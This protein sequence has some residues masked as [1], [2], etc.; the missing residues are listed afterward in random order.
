MTNPTS[1]FNWQMPTASDLVT[2]L[3]ADFETFG[4]AVDTSLADLKGGTTG[5]V[6]SKASNT[7]MDFNWVAADDTNAIQ[8]TI[9]DAK[10]DLIS[11]TGSDVPARLAVGANGETLVADSST[12]TGLRYQSGYNGNVVINGGFDVWQRSTSA[13][14]AGTVIYP[15]VDRWI[16]VALGSSPTCTM[17]RQTADTTNLTYG[18]RFGRNSGQTAI[19]DVYVGSAFE[20]IDSKRFAGQTVTLSFSVKAGANAPTSFVSSIRTGT[21]TD[22]SAATLFGAGWTGGV[23]NSQTNTVTTTMTRYTQTVTLG[24]TANQ[25]MLL[26]SY[27]PTGTAGANE[28]FQIEGVQ[29]ELG[30]AATSFKRSGSGGGTIQG[31]LAACQRY[32]PSIQVSAS[33]IAIGQ[34]YAATATLISIPFP[35]TARVAPTGVTVNSAGNFRLRNATSS[36]LTCTSLLFSTASTQSASLDG[37]VASGLVAGNATNLYNA[38]SGTILFTGCEL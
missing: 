28:W 10:G 32:L 38:G 23:N 3:P 33:D 9:V 30:S 24:S 13:T 20:S 22:Q 31:E 11:A 5:Q 27:T 37:N 15:A 18:M 19:G 25:I 34:A 36:L 6:L 16:G 35:V 8:N 26:F 14:F 1:N 2:D 29:L 12:S 21:G 7:D 4:Q 17:S